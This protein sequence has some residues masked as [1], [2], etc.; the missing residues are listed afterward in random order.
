MVQLFK[1]SLFF[2]LNVCMMYNAVFHY[3]LTDL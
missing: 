2:Y 3:N 1:F